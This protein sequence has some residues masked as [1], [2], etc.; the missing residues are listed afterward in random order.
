MIMLV[1]VRFDDLIELIGKKMTLERLEDV[2]FLLKAEV[3]RVD[4]D[5]VE[6]EVNPDRT[7]MLSVEGIARAVK[8]FLGLQTGLV[9]YKVKKSG[10]EVIV[11]PG[12]KKIR[13]FISCGIVKGV[14]NSDDLI[15]NAMWLQESLTSTHGRNRKKASIGLYVHDEINYPV[16]Y[17]LKKPA[18]IKFVPLAMEQELDGPGIMEQNEKGRLYGS[19]ISGFPKWPLLYDSA[20]EVLSLPPIINSNTLGCVDE[21]TTNIFVEVTGTHKATVDQ[22]LNIMVAALA[23]RGGKIESVTV[24]YPDGTVDESPNYSPRKMTFTLDDVHKI[25]G[26]ELTGAE[27]VGCLEKMCYGARVNAKGKLSVEVP[28]VRTDVLHPVDIIEDVAIGYGFDNIEPTI[29]PTMTAGKLLPLTRIM[30]KV[31]DLLVGAGYQEI[32]SFLLTS[33]ETLSTKMNLTDPF[34][35]TSNPKSRD[36]SVMRNALLPVLMDFTAKNLH[37][38]YPQRIFEVGKVVI[39]DEFQETKAIQVPR[40][41]G[42]VS[43]VTVNI[44]ELIAELSFVLRHLGLES[45]F[46]F[47]AHDH[48]SMI[49]GR[50]GKVLIRGKARGIFG[51]VSPDVLTNFGITRPVVA[52]ELDIP[53]ASKC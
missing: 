18:D 48:P 46:E 15:K 26:L 1:E 33:P 36:Y 44:T 50:T 32:L 34:M 7:D 3:E 29:P 25:L 9:T 45:E 37:A 4:G 8:A 21:D 49:P 13:E 27:V 43:D 14:Q 53:D 22:S 42:L 19:I 30:N 10:H 38:D 52:F 2:L 35:S 41:C 51:E 12:L 6:I 31:R 28:V 17:G 39:P 24:R 11:K 5:L 23:E 16:I 47:A 20:G 40:V